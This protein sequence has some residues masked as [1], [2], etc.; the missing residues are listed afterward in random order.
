MTVL[1]AELRD[2][3]NLL[4]ALAEDTRIEL[5]TLGRKLA[6]L[7][8]PLQARPRHREG[9]PDGY[10]GM[11]RRGPY[12][13]LLLSEWAL[14][15]EAPDEFLRR[16]AA[17]EHL[18]HEFDLRQPAGAM[19]VRAVLDAGP[20]QLGTPRLAQLAVLLALFR[21]AELAGATVAWSVAQAPH[22]VHC[23]FD[24][25]T[26]A[27]MLHARSTQ[28]FIMPELGGEPAAGETWIIGPAPQAAQKHC[29]VLQLRDEDG[30]VQVDLHRPGRAPIGLALPLPAPEKRRRLL[31]QPF[32]VVRPPVAIRH[33][34]NQVKWQAWRSPSQAFE[35]RFLAGTQQFAGFS[36]SGD[37]VVWSLAKAA[38]GKVGKSRLLWQAGEGCH[39]VAVGYTSQQLLLITR[40]LTDRTGQVRTPIGLLT[41]PEPIATGFGH[42]FRHGEWLYLLAA[43]G[44]VWRGRQGDPTVTLLDAGVTAFDG[45]YAIRKGSEGVSVERW[46][47]DQRNGILWWFGAQ[48]PR[49]SGNVVSSRNA[50]MGQ[51][52]AAALGHGGIQIATEAPDPVG[53]TWELVGATCHSAHHNAQWRWLCWQPGTGSFMEVPTGRSFRLPRVPV[54]PSLNGD[55]LGFVSE[56]VTIEVWNWQTVQPL[57]LC[58][59][60]A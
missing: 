24:R 10:R 7:M 16:A 60:V 33:P 44:K 59:G 56:E 32:D 9:E 11:Q 58:H 46:T 13:R 50:E 35:C 14:L 23:T 45:E 5:G 31:Q 8:G 51:F 2:W 54:R 21:R 43:D 12:E 29:H 4:A 52:A 53:L 18:F 49:L 27:A 6:F 47:G 26:V 17:S 41:A 38:H 25:D 1:P 3:A 34:E 19:H 20:D 48:S 22:L 42:A 36:K 40:T 57:L 28:S 37:V 39:L 30:C 55:L 15:D